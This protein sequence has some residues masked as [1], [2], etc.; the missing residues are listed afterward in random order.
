LKSHMYEEIHEQSEV[1]ATILEE[2]WGRVVGAARTLRSR[3]FRFAILAA[4]GTSDNAALYAKYLFEVVLGVPTN[5]ASP[6]TFTLYETRMSL[7][8]VLVVGISQSGES[9]DILET[10][11]KTRQL[12]ASTL[13]IT[14]DE[15]SSLARAAEIHFCLHAGKE[16]RGDEDVHCSTLATLPP[17][18]RTQR[19]GVPSS[20]VA[21]S[22]SAPRGLL[23]TGPSQD[24]QR[25]H[26]PLYG[27]T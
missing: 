17:D 19:K 4:R 7:D 1:L 2:E 13:A 10:V 8:E 12:G 14:N 5:L 9:K 23:V 24:N 11:G 22:G 3:S 18:R 6:S 20:R 25:A 27:P 15:G 26:K 21:R 16:R